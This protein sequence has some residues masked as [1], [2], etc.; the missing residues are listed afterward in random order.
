MIALLFTFTSTKRYV[1]VILKTLCDKF[2]ENNVTTIIYM[3]NRLSDDRMLILIV[4]SV[5]FTMMANIRPNITE[6]NDGKNYNKQ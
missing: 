1:S 3:T 2:L 4:G 6:K 5:I